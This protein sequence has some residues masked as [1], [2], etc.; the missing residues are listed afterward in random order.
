VS[1]VQD[2]LQRVQSRS[3]KEVRFL[4]KSFGDLQS[5]LYK[6]KKICGQGDPNRM[7]D[8]DKADRGFN[9]PTSARTRAL[10]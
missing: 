10:V 8:N 7:S 2:K 6:L 9:V 5:N 3:R 1:S 4:T